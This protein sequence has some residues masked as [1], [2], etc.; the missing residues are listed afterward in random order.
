MPWLLIVVVS[1]HVTST[2]FW[3]GS[4]FTLARTG[5]LAAERLF[6]S[7]M[8]SA[9]LA[10]LTGAYLFHALHGGGFGP[11]EIVLSVGAAAALLALL[12]QAA[13]G[14]PA[15]RGLRDAG[16]GADAARVR[17]AVVYRA[18]AGLLGI[19]AVSMAVARFV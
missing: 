6:R 2:V 12:V 8:G 1:L 19:A 5:A 3:A 4:T 14:A 17:L 18:G 7:Q 10:I 16:P 9:I 11:S 13:G 15:V